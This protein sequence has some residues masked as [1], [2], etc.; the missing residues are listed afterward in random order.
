MPAVFIS[1]AMLQQWAEAGKVQVDG[2]ILILLKENRQVDL[3]PAVR[4]TELLGAEDDPHKLLG[5][6]KTKQQLD[7]IGAEHYMDSVIYGDVAYTVIE[8]F[9]GDLQAS[10][11]REEPPPAM[12]EAQS[13]LSYTPSEELK[14][15][16]RQAISGEGAPA[17]VDVAPQ[18]A[19]AAA[20]EMDTGPTEG[21]DA[22]FAEST[23][24]YDS[25]APAE[26]G[27]AVDHAPASPARSLADAASRVA[28]GEGEGEEDDAEALSRLFLNTVR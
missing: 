12:P 5:K 9:M 11:P 15:K 1:Q 8:G 23:V 18:A 24:S 3:N 28:T 26:G 7:D 25:R 22:G 21:G 19:A 20:P 10:R 4:F 27:P 17:P 2:E 13:T 16:A 6:V 14:E